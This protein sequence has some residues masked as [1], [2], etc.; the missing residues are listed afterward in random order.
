MKEKNALFANGKKYFIRTVTHH[1]VGLCVGTL[2]GFVQLKNASWIADDGRFSQAMKSG[3]FDEVE[4]YPT[5][6]V[7]SVG[8]GSIIDFV[9]FSQELPVEQK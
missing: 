8:I 9:E 3:V 6:M 4:P 7:V 1:Y 5:G 2:D